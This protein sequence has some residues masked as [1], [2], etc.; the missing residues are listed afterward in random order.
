MAKD[1]GQGLFTMDQITRISTIR[2][3]GPMKT[4]A[5]M[6]LESEQNA[7]V[8]EANRHKARSMISTAPSVKSLLLGLS[9]FSLSHQG[10][11]VLR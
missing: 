10:L 1:F 11:K 6:L 5:L 2:E 3:L 7:K 9:N 4:A 8:T